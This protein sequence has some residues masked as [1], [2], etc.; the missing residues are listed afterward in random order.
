MR[1]AFVQGIGCSFNDVCGRIEVGL[2]N[3]QMDNVFAL[4]LKRAG[5]HQYLEGSLRAQA[6]HA[7]GETQLSL[8][9]F[10][11]SITVPIANLQL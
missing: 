1:P 11:H 6:R 2:A 3:L 5:S 7:L 8:R 9:S 4:S 10:A